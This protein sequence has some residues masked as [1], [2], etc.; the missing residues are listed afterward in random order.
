MTLIRLLLV[1][2]LVFAVAFATQPFAGS[3]GDW[4]VEALSYARWAEYQAA[5][6][7]LPF[8]AHAGL[9]SIGLLLLGSVLLFCRISLGAVLFGFG[10]LANVYSRYT[11][12]PT[13]SASCELMVQAGFY[14]LGGLVVGAS[15]S[16]GSHLQPLRGNA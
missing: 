8:A 5:V 4:P 3:R 9:A 13:I 14:V 10:L 6:A 12:I 2:W 11:A 7:R 15:L 1:A 16:R